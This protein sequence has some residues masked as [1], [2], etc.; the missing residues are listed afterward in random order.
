MIFW[1]KVQYYKILLYVKAKYRRFKHR[2]DDT[3]IY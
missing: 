3:F 1:V 2:N